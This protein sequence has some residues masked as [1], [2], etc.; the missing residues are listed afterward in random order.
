M[1]AASLLT[2]A[3]ITPAAS[4]FSL[5]EAAPPTRINGGTGIYRNAHGL[6]TPKNFGN[7]TDFAIRVTY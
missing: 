1:L 3:V 5:S 4:A 6:I 2:L 7:N